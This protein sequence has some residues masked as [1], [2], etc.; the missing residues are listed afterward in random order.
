[1]HQINSKGSYVKF[2]NVIGPTD[3]VVTL[4]NSVFSESE[5]LNCLATESQLSDASR[6]SLF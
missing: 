4:I 6:W 3:K 2:L 5:I 1:M